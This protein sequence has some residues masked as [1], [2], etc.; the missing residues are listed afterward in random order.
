MI[1]LTAL[2][3]RMLD[4]F[5]QHSTRQKLQWL[6]EEGVAT[7]RAL[8]VTRLTCAPCDS[9]RR[10][11]AALSGRKKSVNQSQAEEQRVSLTSTLQNEQRYLP[12]AF[13]IIANIVV[14]YGFYESI[15]G[16]TASLRALATVAATEEAPETRSLSDKLIALR[17]ILTPTGAWIREDAVADAEDLRKKKEDEQRRLRDE[18]EAHRL[19][20]LATENARRARLRAKKLGLGLDPDVPRLPEIECALPRIL[21][22][23]ENERVVLRVGARFATQVDWF[24]N[25][26]A[27]FTS[28][29][30]PADPEI[31]TRGPYPGTIVVSRATRRSVGDYH[32]V[33]GNEEGSVSSPT[34]QLKLLALGA[35]LVSSR[36][37]KTAPVGTIVGF[38][39]PDSTPSVALCFGKSVSVYDV[40]TLAPAASIHRLVTETV[41]SV[42]GAAWSQDTSELVVAGATATKRRVA[43]IAW[44]RSA[45][46]S[47]T[48]KASNSTAAPLKT[49]AKRLSVVTR[50]NNTATDATAAHLR[51]VRDVSTNLAAIESV[52][53]AA[54]GRVVV[55]S[56]LQ[57][58]IAV[59]EMRDAVWSLAQAVT[60]STD[61]RIVHVATSASLVAVCF[62]LKSF[63]ELR[64]LASS[65]SSSSASL[66]SSSSSVQRKQWRLSFAFPVHRM[67]FEGSGFA[68]AVA[69]GTAMKTWISVVD[70]SAS[71]LPSY[72]STSRFVAHV[73]KVTSIEW[74]QWTSLLVSAGH[75]GYVKVWQLEPQAVCVYRVHLDMRG[76]RFMAL[77][78]V[79]TEDE[80]RETRTLV[81]TVS[82]SAV[83]ETRELVGMHA[84]E[85]T[86]RM[87][88]DRSAT[89]IQR[90]WKGRQTRELIAKYIK[91][92]DP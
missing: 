47:D 74:T 4:V 2:L 52:T 68:L 59:F 65:S 44:Q 43:S 75:D 83:L 45:L 28:Q 3:D 90:M 20:A 63:I 67:A 78:E 48:L 55:L 34:I 40:F 46:S 82:F 84:F 1:S 17:R 11:S 30:S 69:E 38:V 23:A 15:D 32:C 91:V 22:V 41:G 71:L 81:A 79:T 21:C 27:L 49:D 92:E 16:I 56:D 53:T 31:V 76:V 24:F 51:S 60:F 6:A 13:D 73:G 37:L 33:C 10:P 19:Q 14:K 66:S 5:E 88:L 12:Y 18:E 58:S 72:R 64:E 89:H 9:G 86:R 80:Q 29:S 8:P 36:K 85:A 50:A 26:R 7:V 62:R 77:L 70:P 87:K 54:A 61:E 42:A 57:H 25:G 39:A 35:R